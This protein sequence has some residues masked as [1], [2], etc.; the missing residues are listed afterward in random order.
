VQTLDPDSSLAL[1]RRAIA[2]RPE[3]SGP[4]EW[5]DSPRGTLVFARGNVLCLVN[6]DAEPLPLPAGEVLVATDASPLPPGGAAWV[7]SA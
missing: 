5:R 6:V 3:L 2:A 1:H 4:L 7:R